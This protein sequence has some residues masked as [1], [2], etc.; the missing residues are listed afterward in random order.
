MLITKMRIFIDSGWAG[1]VDI[2]I[3]SLLFLRKIVKT[4]TPLRLRMFF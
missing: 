4:L 3:N 2:C 1:Y